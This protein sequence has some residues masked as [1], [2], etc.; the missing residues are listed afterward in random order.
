MDHAL[1]LGPLL[2]HGLVHALC[3][4]GA[5]SMPLRSRRQRRGHA[6]QRPPLL[7]GGWAARPRGPPGDR[8][9]H[10]SHRRADQRRP[11][12]PGWPQRG[13]GTPGARPYRQ[14]RR[15]AHARRRRRVRG[16][17]RGAGS[18][19]GH[20][21]RCV[22]ARVAC[23]T[24]RGARAS[25]GRRRSRTWGAGRPRLRPASVDELSIVSQLV[26]A[27]AAGQISVDDAVGRSR[28]RKMRR[29]PR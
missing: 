3:C 23:H 1:A 20:R 16:R 5:R 25:A 7:R 13:A 10:P 15:R 24:R 18:A 26:R 17:S 8:H 27:V 28:I 4:V 12:G 2:R 19:A 9:D 21:R 29:C 22:S 14:R 6:C 11:A